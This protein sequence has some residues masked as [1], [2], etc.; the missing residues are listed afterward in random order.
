MTRNS[1]RSNNGN[2]VV[3]ESENVVTEDSP[4]EIIVPKK[5]VRNTRKAKQEHGVPK[6][7]KDKFL[8]VEGEAPYVAPISGM[9]FSPI[10]ANQKKAMQYMREGRQVVA[11]TGV[12]GSGKSL[13]AAFHASEL[14]KNK[15]IDKIYLTRAIVPCG[16]S[17]GSLPGTIKDKS[18]MWVA[19][20][21]RHI[22][23]FLGVGFTKYCLDKDIIEIVA[24]E[25]MRGRSFED[26]VV[27]LE[28]AQALTEDE[29]EMILTRIGKGSQLVFT[30]DSNQTDNRNSGLASTIALFDKVRKEHPEYLDQSDIEEITNNIGI[31]KFTFDDIQRSGLV[32][33]FTKMYYYN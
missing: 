14:L 33:A 16:K 17:N 30:G 26:C 19:Q 15:K 9:Q 21:I 31:V 7:V 3:V 10:G 23:K 24:I 5:R 32:R 8:P 13:L 25:S 2:N 6:N 4:Y 18:L 22:E 12:A 11:L 27:I 20:T 29:L 28:E 1:R